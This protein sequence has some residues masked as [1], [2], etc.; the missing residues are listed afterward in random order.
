MLKKTIT[1]TDFDDVVRTETFYF[2]LTQAEALELEVSSTGGLQ[3]MIDRIINADDR[4]KLIELFKEVILKAYGEKSDDGKHFVKSQE[5]RDRFAQTMAYS[6][7]F[8]ELATNTNSATEFM[9][10]IVPLPI[11]TPDTPAKKE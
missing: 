5:L 1:Y 2:N 7:L 9:N 11:P 4:K 6:D 3:K 8:I 10:G